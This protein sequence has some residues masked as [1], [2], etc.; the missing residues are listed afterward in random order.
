MDLNGLCVVLNSS[1]LMDSSTCLLSEHRSL[2][3]VLVRCL[4]PDTLQRVYNTCFS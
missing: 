1:A 2:A 4:V 3:S